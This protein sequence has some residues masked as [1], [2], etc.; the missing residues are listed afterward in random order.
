MEQR[1][2]SRLV[3]EFSRIPDVNTIRV[4]EIPDDYKYMDPELV[5]QIEQSV[6]A[7]LGF[8]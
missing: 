2:K 4:L 8:D 5:E 7:I 6:S 3:R 1:H